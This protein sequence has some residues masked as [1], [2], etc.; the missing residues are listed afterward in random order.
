[1]VLGLTEF[2][3]EK[4]NPDHLTAIGFD[5]TG[6]FNSS[7]PAKNNERQNMKRG[8]MRHAETHTRLLFLVEIKLGFPLN[9]Q[10][11]TS[12]L[13]NQAVFSTTPQKVKL[14][15]C[16]GVVTATKAL[17]LPLLLP[18]LQEQMLGPQRNPKETYQVR[19]PS[20]PGA[21]PLTVSFLVGRVLLKWTTEKRK[22]TN[23]F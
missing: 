4:G 21:R 13:G 18:A 23:L 15:F 22:G 1:M 16:R 19:E 9:P 14:T 8:A 12:F 10:N 2:V 11:W 17:P 6:P 20:S 7:P 5:H 3:S